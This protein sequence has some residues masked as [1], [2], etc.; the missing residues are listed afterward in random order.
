MGKDKYEDVSDAGCGHWNK[1][2]DYSATFFIGK[3]LDDEKLVADYKIEEKNFVVIMVTK[4]RLFPEFVY[5]NVSMIPCL[6]LDHQVKY[7]IINVCLQIIS[8]QHQLY[9]N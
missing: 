8:T 9:E 7:S 1:Y 5:L 6:G 4:V 3:I 2:F